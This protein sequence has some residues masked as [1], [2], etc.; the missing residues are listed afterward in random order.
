MRILEMPEKE[1]DALPAELKG[2]A[3]ERKFRH[4]H[5]WRVGTC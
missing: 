2:H 1:S 3:V 4:T 5:K